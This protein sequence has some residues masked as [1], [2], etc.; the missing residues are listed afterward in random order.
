MKQMEMEARQ[1]EDPTQ[2]KAQQDKILQ[3]KKSVR[4]SCEETQRSDLMG[5]KSAGQR[6]RLQDANDQLLRQNELLANAQ[7]TVAA[8]EDIGTT[9]SAEL[10]QNRTKIEA[11]TA[12][13]NEFSAITDSAK[14][15]VKR[16]ENREKCVVS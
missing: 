7:R 6:H 12:K 4:E 5:N 11:S 14:G 8:T 15:F 10:L 2:K 13:V 9:I 16:M 3:H 1:T